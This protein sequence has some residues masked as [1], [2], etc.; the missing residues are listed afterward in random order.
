MQDYSVFSLVMWMMEYTW[1]NEDKIRF[2]DYFDKSEKWPGINKTELIEDHVLCPL[3]TGQ[4]IIVLGY[5]K[6]TFLLVRY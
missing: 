4:E 3:R 1:G 5:S 2:Q 6:R